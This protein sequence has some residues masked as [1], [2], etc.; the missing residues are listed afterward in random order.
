MGASHGHGKGRVL[1]A[2]GNVP[3][4]HPQAPPTI[5]RYEHNLIRRESLNYSPSVDPNLPTTTAAVTRYNELRKVLKETKERFAATKDALVETET[6][7][8]EAL[9]EVGQLQA[10][11]SLNVPVSQLRGQMELLQ[12]L[13]FLRKE[14]TDMR[15]GLDGVALEAPPAAHGHPHGDGHGYGREDL[16]GV[17]ADDLRLER[18]TR[19]KF[20]R[21]T[22]YD[23]MPEADPEVRLARLTNDHR[24]LLDFMHKD[25]EQAAHLAGE[26]DV[27]LAEVVTLKEQQCVSDGSLEAAKRVMDEAAHETQ[28][29]QMQVDEGRVKLRRMELVLGKAQEARDRFG[30]ALDVQAEELEVTCGRVRT[31]EAALEESERAHEAAAEEAERAAAR[32]DALER[33]MDR[34]A[35]DLGGVRAV[36]SRSSRLVDAGPSSVTDDGGGGGDGDHV[37]MVERRSRVVGESAS[38]SNSESMLERRIREAEE[39]LLKEHGTGTGATEDAATP[40][41]GAAGAAEDDYHS[42]LTSRSVHAAAAAAASSAAVGMA[43]V[44]VDGSLVTTETLEELRQV[45]GAV[46]ALSEA[47]LCFLRRRDETEGAGPAVASG[48]GGTVNKDHSWVELKELEGLSGPLSQLLGELRRDWKGARAAAEAAD[49][50]ARHAAERSDVVERAAGAAGCEGAAALEAAQQQLQSQADE[51][52]ALQSDC[53][54]YM[55]VTPCGTLSRNTTM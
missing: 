36:S 27:T 5:A 46:G 13:T 50:R 37:P 53:S 21:E 7:R 18:L 9:C 31:V 32:A 51:C 41:K 43:G 42:Y 55:Q 15:A 10:A 33:E 45:D 30:E 20:M 16:S 24:C 35:E 52:S 29:L 47:L 2:K 48:G 25:Y 11:L 54:R 14:V 26:L 19:I 34:L 49:T 17:D 22:D 3:S 40:V 6:E 8:D 12:K 23:H 28:T 44:A 4:G 38:H 1:A 39:D